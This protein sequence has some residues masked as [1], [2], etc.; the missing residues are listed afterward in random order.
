MAAL[1]SGVVGAPTLEE[2]LQLVLLYA[3]NALQKL[4]RAALRCL[5][6][7]IDETKDVSLLTAQ[8]A[9]AALSELRTGPGE[10]AAKLL[11]GLARQE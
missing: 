5:T 7:Y 1:A 9:V 4:E 2:E 10:A 6:R 8:L 11:L 3:A